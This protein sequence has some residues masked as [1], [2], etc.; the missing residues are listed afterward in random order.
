MH[1]YRTKKWIIFFSQIELCRSK[2][3]QPLINDVIWCLALGCETSVVYNWSFCRKCSIND[4]P[5]WCHFACSLKK[6]HG[7][8]QEAFWSEGECVVCLKQGGKVLFFKLHAKW[9]YIGTSLVQQFPQKN[10]CLLLRHLLMFPKLDVRLYWSFFD[11]KFTQLCFSIICESCALTAQQYWLHT[12]PKQTYHSFPQP[13]CLNRTSN[14]YKTRV[15][16][17]QPFICRE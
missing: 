9:R 13:F 12:Y 15:G 1:F 2:I 10:N 5:T 4:P 14:I 7:L 6:G 8:V 3:W 11:C 17:V 16:S